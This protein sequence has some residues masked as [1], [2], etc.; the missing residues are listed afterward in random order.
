MA[1]TRK[2]QSAIEPGPQAPPGT[3]T[4]AMLLAALERGTDADRV[5]ALKDA[6]ILDARGRVTK[7]YKDWG[8]KV[9]RT[10]DADEANPQ[11]P[12]SP[13]APR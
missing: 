5:A 4:P 1:K 13:A 8:T 12:R 10:P 3:W 11:R 7:R 9:T 2:K 6:G